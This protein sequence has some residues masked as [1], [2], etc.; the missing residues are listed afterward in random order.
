[1]PSDTVRPRATAARGGLEPRT[2]A[3]AARLEADIQETARDL[4][5]RVDRSR[6][7]PLS[8]ARW[9]DEMMDWAMADERL[10]V[11]LFR[12]VDVFPTLTTDAEIARHLQ[13][14]FLQPGVEAPRTLRVALRA[15][16]RRSPLRPAA[17]RAVRA[18]MLSFAHRFIVGSDAR[19]ALP[20]LRALRERGVGFT[21]DVLG[22]A[23]VSAREAA[24]Y[25][26]RY[27]DLLDDLTAEA[28]SWP[29]APA[30]DGAAWGTLPRVNVSIKIT[31]LY[32]QID[33]LDFRG[34]V[35]AVKEALRPVVRRAMASGAFLN[36]DLEQF[37]YRDLTYTVFTELLDEE[38]F[39][40]FDQ[41]GVVVQAYLRDAAD[42]LRAL[43]DWGRSRGRPLTVR[44]VK[45]AYWDY[46]TVLASQERWPTPVFT[47]KPDSDAAFE[48]L[49]HLMLE[50]VDV[51]RPAFAS[52]NVR[53]LAAAI[54]TAR[55]IGVPDD[56]F[57]LQMLRG[58]GDPIKAAVR[59]LGLRLREY[60]PVGE[61]IPGMAYFVRRLLENTANESFLR[62]AFAAGAEVNE[63][64]APPLPSADLDEPPAQL[65]VV[66]PTDPDAPAPFANTPHADFARLECR[67]A[68]LRALRLAA[69][70]PPRRE[71]LLIGGRER[72]GGATAESIDPAR[73]TRVVGV[74]DIA[75]PAEVDEA[76]RAAVRAFPEWRGAAAR[77]RAAVLFKA[78]ELMRGELAELA[79]LETLEAGKTIREAD[80]DVA[81][82]IDF[83][84]YYGREALRL[85]VPRRLGAL[86]G[87]R[88]DQSYEALGVAAVIAPWNFPLAIL[89]GMTSA[90]LV[91]GNA[92]VLKPA[93]PTPVLGAQLARIL[94]AAGA[95]PGTVNLLNGAGGQIGEALVGHPDVHL[96]AFT[97]SRAVGLRIMTGAVERPGRAWIKRLICE[98][99]GKNAIIVDGDADLDVAVLETVASAFGYQGQKCSAC[100]RAIVLAGAYDE[101]LD[102]LVEATRSLVVGPPDDPA[103][104]VGPVISAE[105]RATI[106]GYLEQ[107]RRE[108]ALALE[109]RPP[110]GGWPDGG[111]Y[112]GPH[113][114]AGVDPQTTIAQEEI[115]GPVL[116]VMKARDLDEALEIANGTSYALTGG[117][118]SRS[119]AAIARVRREF[120]V[121]NLYINRGIT[122]AMVERQPF[123][124]FK[125]SGTGS[126]AGGADYL[127]QF[128]VPRVVTENTLRRGF[129]PSDD[130]LSV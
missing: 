48:R 97:G 100:S 68:A 111:F 81:E 4:F 71:A 14:Y 32:S 123:G 51:V 80:A 58:M 79:A 38:E 94:R 27:L 78:A 74:V 20:G 50:S 52:H 21:I 56:G 54:A 42:D 116:A 75:G 36:L 87:E 53:S 112:V 43:I 102:R 82:A 2:G 35:D 96:I 90:A 121:G 84:E 126:K 66:E 108:A 13:E 41:A 91:A 67:R 30:V 77:E 33:P 92:V 59:A 72:R 109:T 86:P 62:G 15:A 117:L 85:G 8:Q 22:E 107:G 73:P 119:P 65:P 122:G 89:T 70:R 104:R 3:E 31:S 24:A 128:L 83:L 129:A 103:T 40:A 57:E 105:A 106:E 6:P 7:S 99:G 18:E 63:L 61:L 37:R 34:S 12:F 124:G 9:Q 125:M 110:A 114:F 55:R 28:A 11:E 60:T 69:E 95:P 17:V 49:A 39:R 76:V 44:L 5:S 19:S 23:S 26:R 93:G 120:R 47:H 46:E 127:R 113:I 98:L 16:G 101:F 88:N 29:A 10:K 118:I 1:V 64:I 25:Q 45:G 115:F 130:G